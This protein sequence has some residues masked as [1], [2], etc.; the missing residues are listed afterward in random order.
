MKKLVGILLLIL[1]FAAFGATQKAPDFKAVDQYNVEQ[2][3]E[4]YKGK[5]IVLTFWATWCPACQKELGG[6]DNL[7][8]KY[9]E[10][11]KD[12]VFL[13]VANEDMDIVKNFLQKRNYS[14]PSVQSEDAFR[15][16][17]VRAFPTTYMIDKDGN[18]SNFLMGAIPED[19]L[20]KYIQIELQ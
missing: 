12:V 10:N 13:G 19:S 11:K 1:S 14:Y 16:F 17:F 20:D 8:K 4:K 15:K 18:I 2:S 9:G 7:Y 5:F 3:I 6:L